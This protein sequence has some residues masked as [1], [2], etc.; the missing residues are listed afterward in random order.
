MDFSYRKR[1][2]RNMCQNNSQLEVNYFNIP[3]VNNCK[4]FSAN[5]L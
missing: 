4:F 3:E 5:V 2:R 1:N